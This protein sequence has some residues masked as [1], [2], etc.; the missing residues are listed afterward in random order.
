[1]TTKNQKL[2]SSEDIQLMREQ[3]NELPDVTQERLKKKDVL[4]SLKSDIN[5]LIN[6]KGYTINEVLDHLKNFGV[7]DVTLKDLKAITEGKKPR[8]RRAGA[9][10]SVNKTPTPTPDNSVNS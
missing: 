9:A 5:T 7:A 6:A 2:Y 4:E 10:I 1:M 8:Q 3:L